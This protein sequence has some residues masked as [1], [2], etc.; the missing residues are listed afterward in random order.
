MAEDSLKARFA[1]LHAQREREWPEA[2]LR[3]NIEQR[4][5]LVGR[6]D[7]STHVQKGDTVAPFD[8]IG[9]DGGTLSRDTLI[10][11]G[12]AILVFYR[13]GGCPACNIALPYYDN[14][15]LPALSRA[16]IP[17]V[18]VSPQ[19]P[20][21]PELRARHGLGLILAS[22]PG[23][24]LGRRLGITFEPDEKPVV[25][26]GESWIGSITG[27]GTWELPQPTVLI[28]G[29]DAKVRFISVSPDWLQRPEPDEILAALPELRAVAA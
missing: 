29:R 6:Y 5:A 10:Q 11:G 26:P 9:E 17:L 1:A 7:P 14:A 19:Q 12:P 2:Q 22:D 23:N 20:V 21:D 18:A 25:T 24:A 28:L 15:L 16:H 13:F 27:T 8:L 4:E 3:K